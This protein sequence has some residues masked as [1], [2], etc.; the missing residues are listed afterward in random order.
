MAKPPQ[1][2]TELRREIERVDHA[3]ASTILRRLALAR[4]V[5]RAKASGGWPLRDYG[6]ERS[7]LRRWQKG[8]SRAGVSPSRAHAVGR[9]LVEEALR[10]QEAERSKQSSAGLRG[11]PD[12]A[13]VGGAGAMGRWLADFLEDGG[14]RVAIVDPALSEPGRASFPDIETAAEK[15][16]VLAFATPVR[17]TAPLLRRAIDTGTRA[18]LFDVLSVKAPI[19]PLLAQAAR[20]GMQVTS[21]H[22]MFGPSARTLSGRNL[23]IVS[24]GV[25]AADRAARSLFARSAL[26]I[27][28]VPL[29]RHDLLIAES[30]GMS[31]AVNLLFMATLGADPVSPHELARAASTTFHRQ[32]ALAALVASE[33]P[34]LYLDIQALNP[35]S[36]SIYEELRSGLD[37]LASVVEQQDRKGF[38]EILAAGQ[39]KLQPGEPSLRS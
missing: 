16:K 5:G 2:I 7:V 11:P 23:L 19:A 21:V 30:L 37:R 14:H 17:S 31:H 1:S 3:L 9:W 27:A 29:E 12:A 35:H 13:I 25:P 8:L 6:V 34:D 36:W 28:E 10:V 15:V 26:T 39:A 38:R 22:P 20:S 18:L 4:A 24:C 32:S 33:G